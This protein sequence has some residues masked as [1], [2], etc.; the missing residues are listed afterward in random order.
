[1][2]TSDPFE[3]DFAQALIDI[4]AEPPFDLATWSGGSPWRRFAVHRNQ[5]MAGLTDALADSFPVVRQLVG[6]VYFAALA[7]EFIRRH[8]PRSPV[9]H[10]WGATLPDW[11]DA[12][13][14]LAQLPYL[15][16]VA[17]VEWARIRAFHAADAAALTPDA[18][19]ATLGLANDLSSVHLHC[20]P[21]LQTLQLSRA[22]ASLWQAH[23]T[24]DPSTL[25]DR[26]AR[27]DTNRAECALVHRFGDAVHVLPV[28]RGTAALAAALAQ[29]MDL[30]SASTAAQAVSPQPVEL[31]TA[32]ARLLH[33]RILVQA[34]RPRTTLEE[35][36][37]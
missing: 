21:S 13:E 12:F 20:C 36:T 11:L 18:L 15:A 9:L 31:A 19:A 14:P 30:A 10:E 8:P 29:G 4:A 37:P 26:L 32:L 16:D 22:G 24:D 33:A 34:S 28:D 7:P 35:I 2:L 17:R 27:L 1:M 25:G 6:E 3:R 5:F 23:Q